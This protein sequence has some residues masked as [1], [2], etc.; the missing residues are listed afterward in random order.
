MTAEDLL[1][2]PEERFFEVYNGHPGVRNYGD[3]W[4]TG[5]ERIWDIL[6]T[7]RLAEQDEAPVYGLA[8]DDA[9]NYQSEA[10][11]LSNPG[12]GWIMVRAEKLTAEAIVA[13]LEAGDFYATSGVRL[14]DIQEDAEGLTITIDTEQGVDYTTTFIG[15]RRGYD[16]GSEPVVGA[17]GQ[18]LPVTRRYSDDIGETLAVVK[19]AVGRYDFA[20][21]EIYVRARVTSSKLKANSFLEGDMETAWTQ[22]V[23]PEK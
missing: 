17:D 19:G 5:V 10:G 15:T 3:D 1:E 13:A 14:K 23:A 20:G 11:D 2:V 22:P 21:D 16:A 18:H 9:H 7:K 4:H 12:R 8:V 6:L